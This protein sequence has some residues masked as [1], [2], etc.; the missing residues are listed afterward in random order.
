[1]QEDLREKFNSWNVKK[2]EVEFSNRTEN[3]YFKEGEIWWCSVG[4]N[5]GSESFG[6]GENFMR[7]ILI[8]KKLS[9]DLCIALPL[10]SKE[11]IGTWFT[12]ITFDGQKICVLLYQIRAFN[13]KRFQRKMGELDQKDFLRVKEKLEK[14]LELS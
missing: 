1:M 6:K 14:L 7:P 10:T 9:S 13:K 5:V 3:I 2:Q 4:Q 12:D 11:K 8:I